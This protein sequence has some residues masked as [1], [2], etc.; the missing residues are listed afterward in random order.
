MAASPVVAV[1]KVEN[2]RL[3]VGS[4]AGKIDPRCLACPN[5][6]HENANEAESVMHQ[7]D[8]DLSTQF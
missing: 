6:V 8:M 7:R 5:G 4:C 3:L 1:A 2:R